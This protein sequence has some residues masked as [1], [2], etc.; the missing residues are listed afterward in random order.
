M[1][2][3]LSVSGCVRGLL[4]KQERDVSVCASACALYVLVSMTRPVTRT[5]GMHERSRVEVES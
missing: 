1:V 4:A 5:Q 3:S 2:P